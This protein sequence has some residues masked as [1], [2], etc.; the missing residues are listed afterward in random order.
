MSFWNLH[1]KFRL[2]SAFWFNLNGGE[3]II[4]VPW[5]LQ[6]C[7]GI[8]PTLREIRGVKYSFPTLGEVGVSNIN[9]GRDA[10]ADLRKSA[11]EKFAS[12]DGKTSAADRFICGFGQN[13]EDFDA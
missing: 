12:A 2:P 1:E 13:Q 9:Q 11:E 6:V 4:A 7:K 8:V 3:P 10:S 5:F